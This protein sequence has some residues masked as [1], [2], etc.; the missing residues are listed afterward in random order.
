MTV[1]GVRQDLDFTTDR[2]GDCRHP[3]PLRDV[4]YTGDEERV[5]YH[6]RPEELADAFAAGRTP[7][8]ME[9]AGPRERIFFDPA[10]DRLRHR[11]LRRPV[12]GAQRRHPRHR[13]EPASSLRCPEDLRLPLRLRGAGEAPW[14]CAPGTDAGGGEPDRR[15]WAGR[16]SAPR[17]GRRIR[18]RWSTLW[19]S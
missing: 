17:A 19:K 10:T 16:S 18:R 2:L 14:A 11:H 6:T 4:R 8:A 12:P 9:L 15:D 5:I 1:A 7:P 13:P 3:S